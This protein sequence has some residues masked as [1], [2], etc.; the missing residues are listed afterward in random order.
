[1]VWCIET[2]SFTLALVTLVG[3]CRFVRGG[4]GHGKAHRELR[5]EAAGQNRKMRG[6]PS[7]A[8]GQHH[9]SHVWCAGG[10]LRLRPGGVCL[11]KGAHE[12]EGQR[13]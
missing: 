12:T 11:M 10:L 2:K 13:S 4:D 7:I 1:M 8:S 6:E 3:P 9:G 5:R